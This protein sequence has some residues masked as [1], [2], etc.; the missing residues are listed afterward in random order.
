MAIVDERGVRGFI[1]DIVQM[2]PDAEPL[3]VYPRVEQDL[4]NINQM[5]S[6]LPSVP[7]RL[8]YYIEIGIAMV[9]T[10][11]YLPNQA[12]IDEFPREKVISGYMQFYS[13]E[14]ALGWVNAL[15]RYFPEK[16]ALLQFIADLRTSNPVL[17]SKQILM[18]VLERPDIT[19]DEI[20]MVGW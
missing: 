6:Q 14:G 19:N 5:I 8:Q 17:T 4:T 16:I 11:A 9:D 2:F 10:L 20:L 3:F 18:Q 12:A 15:I 1:A 7:T 13:E